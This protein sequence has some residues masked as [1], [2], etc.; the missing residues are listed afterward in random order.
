MAGVH[1]FM[2]IRRLAFLFVIIVFAVRISNAQEQAIKADDFVDSIGV[3]THLAYTNT[4]YYQQYTQVIAA[5]SAAGIRHIRDGYYLWS[6]GNQMYKI[7]QAVSAA[8]IRT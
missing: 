2:V 3:N 7:H 5:L 8:G 4:Y 1:R 6:T